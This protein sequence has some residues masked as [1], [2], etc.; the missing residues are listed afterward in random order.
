MVLLE[1]VGSSLMIGSMRDLRSRARARKP[2]PTFLHARA[3]KPV[4]T[5]FNT[6]QAETA[7]LSNFLSD[8]PYGAFAT[9]RSVMMAVT[10]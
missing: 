6:Y 7:S 8:S 5:F 9:P 1:R 10:Y 2:V 4:P 3:W